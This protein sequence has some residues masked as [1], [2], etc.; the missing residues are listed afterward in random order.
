MSDPKKPAKKSYSKYLLL[1]F[2]CLLI[3]GTFGAKTLLLVDNDLEI[4]TTFAG[5]SWQLDSQSIR[6]YASG[7]EKFVAQYL[8]PIGKKLHQE[9]NQLLVRASNVRINR[10][11][12]CN[13]TS[14]FSTVIDSSTQTITGKSS[15]SK[16]VKTAN[17]AL[18]S[19]CVTN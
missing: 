19:W 8:N 16:V 7:S 14:K 1:G 17:P 9:S 12:L 3:G 10:Q 5:K 18:P 15:N 13:F 4:K 6:K 2:I 11:D